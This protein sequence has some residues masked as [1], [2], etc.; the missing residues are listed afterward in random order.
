[1]VSCQVLIAN[2]AKKELQRVSKNVRSRVIEVLGGLEQ[3]PRP[4]GAVKLRGKS[5]LWRVRIGDYR[6]IYAID[7]DQ[8]MVD[9]SAIRHRSDA[10]R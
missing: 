6:V 1:M 8:R 3:K 10:Y 4:N 5:G 7:D 9:V 2:S